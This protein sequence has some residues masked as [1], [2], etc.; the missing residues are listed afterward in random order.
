MDMEMKDAGDLRPAKRQRYASIGKGGV[1]AQKRTWYKNGRQYGKKKF[2]KTKKALIPYEPSLAN[3]IHTFQESVSATV[4]NNASPA[5]HGYTFSISNVTDYAA[6]L[7]LFEEFRFDR[8]TVTAYQTQTDS[9]VQAAAMY[10]PTL[11]VAVDPN[12]GVAPASLDEVLQTGRWKQYQLN[13]GLTVIA[14]FVPTLK[15]EVLASAG[16]TT[17]AIKAKTWLSN[18]NVAIQHNGMKLWI[19]PVITGNNGI[20]MIFTYTFSMRFGK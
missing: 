18:E 3:R 12:D 11:T 10:T 13:N 17:T 8:V 9:I 1:Y 15:Y 19:D 4:L 5:G 2:S 14:D 7:G 20:Y 16:V 6:Y